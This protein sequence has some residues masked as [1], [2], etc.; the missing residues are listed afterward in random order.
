MSMLPPHIPQLLSFVVTGTAENPVIDLQF[1]VDM[2]AGAGSIY[3]TDGA[4]QTVIDRATGLPTMRIVGGTD[5]HKIASG[6]LDFSGNHVLIDAPALKPGHT[7][8]VFI[9]PGALS[10]GTGQLFAGIR[11]GDVAGF[12]TPG[13]SSPGPTGPTLVSVEQDG[14]V[15]KTG[16]NIEFKFT[17]S[18]KVAMPNAA[19]FSTPHAQF[20]SFH[21]DDGGTTWYATLQATTAFADVPSNTLALDMTLIYDLEGNAGTG[22]APTLT[23]AVDTMVSSHVMPEVY[24]YDDRGPTGEDF[25]TNGT[26]H[27]IEGTIK[28]VMGPGQHFRLLINGTL[29]EA[30]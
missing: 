8:S 16:T 27:L 10:A 18:E 20:G 19:A 30:T 2:R 3:I 24:L 1:N 11:T 4:A 25:I 17:F 23:Y 26:T 7:Y 13:G 28:D 22:T 14:G 29:V 21:T 12:T 5:T 9:A 15:L 6:S